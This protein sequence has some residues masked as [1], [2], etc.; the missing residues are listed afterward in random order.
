MTH[1]TLASW[2]LVIWRTIESYRFDPVATFTAAGIDV[3]GLHAPGQR[4][5]FAAMQMLW[6]EA[7]TRTADPCF[8]LKTVEFIHPT[9]FH[10]LGYAAMAS[11]TLEDALYRI[12]RYGRLVTT[13]FGAELREDDETLV[14][15]SV[16]DLPEGCPRAHDASVDAGIAAVVQI[17]RSVCGPELSPLEVG[18]SHVAPR[19]A[20]RYYSYF[21]APVRFGVQKPYLVLDKVQARTPLPTANAELALANEK[22]IHDYLARFDRASMATQVRGKIAEQLP[23]GRVTESSVAAALH[24]SPRSMQRRL[25]DEGTSFRA[26]LDD[27]RKELAVQYLSHAYLSLNEI[28]YLLGYAEPASFTRAFRRWKG[29]SPSDYRRERERG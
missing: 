13:V 12:I 8:G 28:S 27:M 18:I 24:L 19:C 26:V 25:Q 9:T 11:D 5:P 4:V 20:D 6:R 14:L 7:T 3:G 29:V 23:S 15:T 10:A 2:A 22:V 1:T 17:C 16:A 21:K